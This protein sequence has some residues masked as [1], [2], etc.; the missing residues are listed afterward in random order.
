VGAG[1]YIG[2]TER[3]LAEA[4][5]KEAERPED[6][7]PAEYAHP[8]CGASLCSIVGTLQ[9][10]TQVHLIDRASAASTHASSWQHVASGNWRARSQTA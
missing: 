2:K 4:M 10:Q 3:L 7:E 8:P 5:A 9:E 6:M 1:F